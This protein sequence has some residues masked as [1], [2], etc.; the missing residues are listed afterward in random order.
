VRVV[1]GRTH[2]LRLDGRPLADVSAWIERQRRLWERK[3]DVV[4]AWLEEEHR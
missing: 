2:R 1:E 3:F 4:D